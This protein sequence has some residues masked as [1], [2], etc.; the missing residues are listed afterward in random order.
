MKPHDQYSRAPFTSFL[1]PLSGEARH[2]R[3]GGHD[4]T[5]VVFDRGRAV[6]GNPE[7][8]A[9]FV[10][11]TG[12]TTIF[13]AFRETH[14]RPPREVVT[15]AFMGDPAPDRVVPDIPD[16]QD[17][18]VRRQPAEVHLTFVAMRAA[19]GEEPS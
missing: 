12:A 7:V 2:S 4:R 11:N 15:A 17:A 10:S 6:A 13:G 18:R 9:G 3:G 8:A 14:R 16:D 1:K 19:Y 5:S